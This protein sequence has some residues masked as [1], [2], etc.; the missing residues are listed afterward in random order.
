M[1]RDGAG[2]APAAGGGQLSDGGGAAP[3][4]VVDNVVK[5]F[6]EIRAVDGVSCE[7]GAGNIIALL[8]PNGAGKTTLIRVLVGILRPDAGSVRFSFDGRQDS[9]LPPALSAYLPEDRGP[10][11]DVAVRRSLA[12]FGVLRGMDWQVAS[13]A[14]DSW[15][16][17]LDLKDRR[18]ALLKELSRGISRRCSL[19]APS[20]MD[21]A[22][23]SSTS[24]SQD[25]IRS[26]RISF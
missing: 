18:D 10:Y 25:S 19:P 1:A 2:G 21:L 20:C 11:G 22:S 13:G 24:R 12:Y 4:L 16:E 26:I 23:P 6:G 8:G 7:V 9:V 17:R 3:T 15:L 5:R 14:A